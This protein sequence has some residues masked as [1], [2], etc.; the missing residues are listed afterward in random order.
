[1]KAFVIK[2]KEGEYFDKENRWFFGP[3]YTCCEHI[4]YTIDDAK[5]HID[6]YGLKDCE[7]VEITIVEGDLEQENKHLKRLLDAKEKIET[8][9]IKGFKKLNEENKQLKEQLAEKDKEIEKLK[10]FMSKW[11][12]ENFES[13]ENHYNY[14]MSLKNREQLMVENEAMKETIAN[15][16]GQKKTSS[17]Q[18]RKRV[19]DEIRQAFSKEDFWLYGDNNKIIIIHEDEFNKILDQIEQ[20]KESMK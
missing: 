19:C 16:L 7:V 8:N 6:Y 9:S 3:D 2:N 15:L 12:F 18:I 4:Y 20:V 5:R 11:H 10:N 17:K 14:L 13:F 1:M